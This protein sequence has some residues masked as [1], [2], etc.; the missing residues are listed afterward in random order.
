M[1]T[2]AQKK[3]TNKEEE[4]VVPC[5]LG[6]TS[7]YLSASLLPPLTC[8]PYIPYDDAICSREEDEETERKGRAPESKHRG[9]LETEEDLGRL[10]C[11]FLLL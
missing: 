7:F 9:N 6:V 4:N 1:Q 10:T 5:K 3:V 2:S 11:F 8:G